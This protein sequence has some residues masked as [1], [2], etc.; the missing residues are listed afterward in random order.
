NK[1]KVEGINEL[2]TLKGKIGD[3]III[4]LEDNKVI[5]AYYPKIKTIPDLTQEQQFWNEQYE[6]GKGIYCPNWEIKRL[7]KNQKQR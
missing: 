7:L 5:K 2:I 1:I 4:E 3:K 6:E